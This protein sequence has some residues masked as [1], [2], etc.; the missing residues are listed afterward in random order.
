MRRGNLGESR[1]DKAG[2]ADVRGEDEDGFGRVV[3]A[4]GRDEYRGALEVGNGN[5]RLE[6][7]GE[8]RDGL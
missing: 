7:L 1:R 8:F 5:E 4:V 6:S 3:A 2:V